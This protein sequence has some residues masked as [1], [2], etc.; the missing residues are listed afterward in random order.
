MEKIFDSAQPH[1]LLP[2]P[3]ARRNRPGPPCCPLPF[4][5]ILAFVSTHVIKLFYLYGGSG[6]DTGEI[7]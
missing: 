1:T 7:P 4:L 2:P 5:T 3:S 6:E